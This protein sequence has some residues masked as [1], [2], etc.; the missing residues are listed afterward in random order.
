MISIASKIMQTSVLLLCV[1]A[2]PNLFAQSSAAPA[3][4][5]S[6]WKTLLTE[7]GSPDFA[8]RTAA[9]LKL[10]ELTADEILSLTEQAHDQPSAEVVMRL[11]AEIESRYQSR[12]PEDIDVASRT[13]EAQANDDRLMLADM[14]Q[15]SLRKHWKKRIEIALAELATHGAIVRRGS[16]TRRRMFN[17]FPGAARGDNAIRILM[18]E[19]WKGGDDELA[20][21]ER[22]SALCGPVTTENGI[23]VF[24]LHGNPLTDEQE[25]RLLTVVG[26][27]RVSKRS[28]VALGIVAYRGMIDGVLI[29]QVTPGSSAQDAG[30][31]PGDLIVAIEPKGS[32]RS[33][34]KQPL[35]ANAEPDGESNLKPDSKPTVDP[36]R[37]REFDDLD[38]RIKRGG[39]SGADTSEEP[40]AESNLKPV[41]PPADPS[42]LRDFDD[43]V[44]RLMDYREGETMT[45][46]VQRGFARNMGGGMFGQLPALPE[47]DAPQ[48]RRNPE[49]TIKVK[50]KGWADLIAE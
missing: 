37:L 11:Q 25:N 18:T 5:D 49:V 26:Q 40:D 35:P 38:D 9:S 48:I 24:L 1:T 50:M 22:L 33:A 28:R 47:Q 6:D 29:E 8:N 13:L 39:P 21:F 2:L 3:N 15:Q 12:N 10:K 43:L 32:S 4:S 45:I 42:L 16:F 7:L 30:L 44:D 17:P 34:E 41:V 46:R 27:N 20:V 14:A 19:T 36:K 23:Q 31:A